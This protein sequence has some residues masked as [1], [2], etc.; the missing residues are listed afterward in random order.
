MSNSYNVFI[1]NEYIDSAFQVKMFIPNSPDFEYINQLVKF[2]HYK[3]EID[4]DKI[5]YPNLLGKY[6]PI[7]IT[8]SGNIIQEQLDL[9]M[10]KLHVASS[11]NDSSWVTNK[12]YK[13]TSDNYLI[14]AKHIYES[15]TI[16]FLGII[17]PNAHSSLFPNDCMKRKISSPLMEKCMH[18]VDIF[19]KRSLNE[20]VSEVEYTRYQIQPMC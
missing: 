18:K 19:Q 15:N 12:G 13:R 16:L 4:N 9:N 10:Y 1:L 17:S 11:L 8:P 5:E 6:S 7:G 20:L 2:I 14:Y 3:E